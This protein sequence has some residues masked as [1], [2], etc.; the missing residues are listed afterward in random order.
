MCAGCGLTFRWECV[1]PSLPSPALTL[2]AY[3]MG[4]SVCDF[5]FLATVGN[6]IWQV[7]SD[8]ACAR[9]QHAAREARGS[10]D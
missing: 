8:A 6:P 1:W 5:A 2:T 4:E 7:I 3:F 10:I 9:P